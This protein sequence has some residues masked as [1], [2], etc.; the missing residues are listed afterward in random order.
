MASLEDTLRAL[1][2]DQSLDQKSR[3]E[4]YKALLATLL[5]AGDIAQIRQFAEHVTSDEVALVVSRQ[6]LQEIAAGLPS[7]PV[8]CG[9]TTVSPTRRKRVQLHAN[10]SVDVAVAASAAALPAGRGRSKRGSSRKSG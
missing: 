4:R 6:V 2:S 1:T 7:L 5:A 8:D 10:G 3:I 9:A